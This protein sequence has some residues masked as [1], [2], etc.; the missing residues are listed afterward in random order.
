MSRLRQVLSVGWRFHPAPTPTADPGSSSTDDDEVQELSAAEFKRQSTRLVRRGLE[1]KNATKGG[2]QMKGLFTNYPIPPCEFVG[3]FVGEWYSDAAYEE[4][5]E[6]EKDEPRQRPFEMYSVRSGEE[7]INGRTVNLVCAPAIA[8]GATSP[9]PE[10]SKLFF[11]NEPS[12]GHRANCIL[13][14]LV[15]EEDELDG[16][17]PNNS[18]GP[19]IAFALIST[20]AIERESELTWHYGTTYSPNRQGYRAGAP[21]TASCDEFNIRDYFPGGVPTRAVSDY[22]PTAADDSSQS[23]GGD[24]EYTEAAFFRLSL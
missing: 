2:M 6:D 7:E 18:G 3:F 8:K 4:L 20:T 19:F 10:R 9:D 15:L 24:P 5:L 23:S 12:E 16:A 13:R 17:P 22:V 1:V 11:A 14:E 21:A